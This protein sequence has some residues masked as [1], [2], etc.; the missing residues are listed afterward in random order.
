MKEALI[1]SLK[2]ASL[3]TLI[4]MLFSL[5][6][7]PLLAFKRFRGR[8]LILGFLTIPLVIPPTVLGF[9]LILLFSPESFL[10]KLITEILGK[11]L[12]FSF[13]GILVAS[14][15]YSLPFAVLPV[16]SAMSEVK[17][18]YIETAYVFGYSKLETYLRVIIPLSLNGIITASILVFAH[19]LGEFGVVLMVGGNIPGET[20]TL[21]IFIYDSV[22]A[23]D[24]ETAHKASLILVAVSLVAVLLSLLL[25][26]KKPNSP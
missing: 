20:Q 12:L 26:R 19:T 22:Q 24:Y 17:R 3:T 9:Y 18:E 4:L 25:E 1:I 21:S 8:A 7:S 11:S 10:G 14:L 13:E 15:V 23:M 6:V 5:I 2:L 16:V